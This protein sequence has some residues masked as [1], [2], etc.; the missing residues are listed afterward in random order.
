MLSCD[1][2]CPQGDKIRTHWA[3]CPEN[4]RVDLYFSKYCG[5]NDLGL[6]SVRKIPHS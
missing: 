2:D 3:E 6:D 5:E 4:K 1:P